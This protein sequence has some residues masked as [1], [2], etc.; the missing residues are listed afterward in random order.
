MQKN[1]KDVTE[2]LSRDMLNKQKPSIAGMGVKSGTL[3]EAR[4]LCQDQ[5][6]LKFLLTWGQEHFD[7]LPP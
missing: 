4:E 7:L 5:K 2:R 1:F 6:E 3:D